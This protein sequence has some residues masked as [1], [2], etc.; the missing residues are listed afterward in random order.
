MR[1]E[2][3]GFVRAGWGTDPV[4]EEGEL[5]GFRVPR[6]VLSRPLSRHSKSTY[7]EEVGS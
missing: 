1:I 5:D 4:E 2:E 7:V 6:V 3:K